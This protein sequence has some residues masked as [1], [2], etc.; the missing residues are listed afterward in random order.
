MADEKK[1]CSCN[2]IGITLE[3]VSAEC[4]APPAIPWTDCGNCMKWFIPIVI[5]RN[6]FNAAGE[7][8]RTTQ[9]QVERTEEIAMC[10]QG[11]QQGK[12]LFTTTLLP[13]EEMRIYHSDRYR[14][15]TSIEARMSVHTSFRQTFAAVWQTRVTSDFSSYTKNILSAR[16]SADTSGSLLGFLGGNVGESVSD[17]NEIGANLRTTADT[18]SQV[19]TSSSLLVDAERSL[20]ISNYE[21]KESVDITS[22][23]LK[24]MNDCRAVNYYIRR[25]NEV[26]EL[27][28]KV[29]GIRFRIITNQKST[30]DW[31]DISQLGTVSEVYQKAIN[32]I[33]QTQPKLGEEIKDIPCI[34]IPT[35]GTMVEAELA[36][37][38]SC[39]PEREAA[40]LINLEKAKSEARKACLEAE[41]LEMEIKRRKALLEAGEL[42]PFEPAPVIE[43][44]D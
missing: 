2:E 11:R 28:V 1:C 27:S 13:G 21:D 15:V 31:L 37:C 30:T 9:V 34:S 42:S 36:H 7:F 17:T 44:E 38:G 19:A 33:L 3:P 41:L 16:E 43:D 6:V 35:D 10:L 23:V 32:E 12:L 14:Q 5:T 18:F 40:L 4:V 26:Y 25:V 22:R 8:V 29:V 39:D 24:N 20:T